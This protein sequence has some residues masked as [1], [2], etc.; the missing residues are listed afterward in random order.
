[1]LAIEP[2]EVSVPPAPV[3]KPHQRACS[4]P[5]TCPSVAAAAVSP[6]PRFE[7]S[8][9]AMKS[10]SAPV[11]FAAAHVPGE[12]AG[13][14]V[15]HRITQA[16]TR[17]TRRRCR[18]AAWGDPVTAVFGSRPWRM[19]SGIGCQTVRWRSSARWADQHHR[20]SGAQRRGPRT[21]RRG[22]GLHEG[23]V[24]HRQVP[25]NSLRANARKAAPVVGAPVK[26]GARTTPHSAELR[27]RG[28]TA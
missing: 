14:D 17:A 5:T 16:P 12:K 9:A 13:M 22:Q 15:A 2:P 27:P 3:R 19:S 25:A 10:A 6:P 1:M 20:P 26:R 24:V 4:Q 23:T 8:M 28:T 11:K 18:R 7:P 21:S